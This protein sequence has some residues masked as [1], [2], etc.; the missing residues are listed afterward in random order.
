MARNKR[1]SRREGP[2]ADLFRSTSS[3]EQPTTS[4]PSVPADEP[5]REDETRTMPADEP[6]AREPRG[7]DAPFDV[8]LNE[9][10]E[11]PRYDPDPEPVRAYRTEA[12]GVERA[13]PE[14]KDRLSR[15][16]ADEP[17]EP[18]PPLYGRHAPRAHE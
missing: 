13:I 16:F 2:L 10:S 1:A 9:P 11:E 18:E 15:I 7:D 5:V 12:P 4:Q 14:P 17:M 3:D 6:S 8:E